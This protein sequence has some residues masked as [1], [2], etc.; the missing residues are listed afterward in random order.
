M[1]TA[2]DSKPGPSDS[3]GRRELWAID[4]PSFDL[5]DDRRSE[6]TFDH[7]RLDPKTITGRKEVDQ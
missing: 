5:L 6:R 1:R 4:A 7:L 3:V 2:P